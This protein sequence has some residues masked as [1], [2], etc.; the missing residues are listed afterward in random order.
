M[1]SKEHNTEPTTSQDSFV[2]AVLEPDQLSEAHKK[3]IPRRRLRGPLLLVVWL[4]RIYLLFM[5]A[6]VAYQV[7]SE[8]H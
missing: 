8:L 6:V 1:T 7:W 3:P 4:M 2:T 5:I